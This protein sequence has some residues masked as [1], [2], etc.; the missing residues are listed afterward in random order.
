MRV[1]ELDNAINILTAKQEI[2]AKLIESGKIETSMELQDFIKY[3][4]LQNT[5]YVKDDTVIPFRVF[6]DMI[7]LVAKGEEQKDL[8]DKLNLI[9]YDFSKLTSISQ[10]DIYL[11]KLDK[12]KFFFII[13]SK[14]YVIES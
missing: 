5:I 8:L 6:D 10:D 7:F 11:G 4:N 3:L 2:E 14:Y 13:D 9:N 1:V 12:Y